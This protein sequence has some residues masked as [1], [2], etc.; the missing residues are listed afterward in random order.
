VA[1]L[2]GV[3]RERSNLETGDKH[4]MNPL[5]RKLVTQRD[6]LVVE[7]VHILKENGRNESIPK[8]IISKN[9]GRPNQPL[10]MVRLRKERRWRLDFL[11]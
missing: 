1:A 10:W 5:E 2:G 7:L 9:L 3:P 11:E 6:I 8:V 4:Q